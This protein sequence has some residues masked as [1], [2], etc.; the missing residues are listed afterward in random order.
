MVVHVGVGKNKL[1]ARLGTA[2]AKPNGLFVVPCGPPTPPSCLSPTL[3]FMATV[4][5]KALP[6]VGRK[7]RKKLMA[8]TAGKSSRSVAGAEA[9]AADKCREICLAEGVDVD[10]SGDDDGDD[11]DDDGKEAPLG[12][13]IEFCADLWAVPLSTLAV[14]VG[15]AALA[16]NL[17]EACRGRDLSQLKSMREIADGRKSVGAEVNY[18]HRYE[19]DALGTA[20]QKAERFL[21]N[22]CEEVVRRLAQVGAAAAHDHMTVS[23]IMNNEL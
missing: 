8:C 15:G 20:M 19:T 11:D 14:W 5:L 6:G 18:G 1:L 7:L 16:K 9:E 22:L 21:L 17:H 10:E 12:G 3:Q 23:W 2:K 4:P 13:S